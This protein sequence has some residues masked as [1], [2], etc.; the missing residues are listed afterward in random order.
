MQWTRLSAVVLGGTLVLGACGGSAQFPSTS[1]AW[2][3]GNDHARLLSADGFMR[4]AKT[5]R[6]SVDEQIKVGGH[7]ATASGAGSID[8]VHKRFSFVLDM[9]AGS[10]NE[11]LAFRF[12]GGKL[13]LRENAGP[14]QVFGS[15]LDPSLGPASDPTTSLAMLKTIADTVR[16]VGREKVRGVDTTHY[17][18]TTSLSDIEGNATLTPDE[19][20]ALETLFGSDPSGATFP[21]DVW[22]D[23][24]GRVR[25]LRISMYAGAV[26]TAVTMTME[27]FAYG[28]PVDIQAPPGA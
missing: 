10:I 17:A 20:T 19:R 25:R 15:G 7:E 6:F 1:P 26:K 18:A 28:S 12:V 11:V 16:E 23:A 3:H 13:Y 27:L 8:L 24:S 22:L 2:K 9:N 14:W 21:I 4:A 5:A